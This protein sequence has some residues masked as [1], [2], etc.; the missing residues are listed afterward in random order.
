MVKAWVTTEELLQDHDSVVCHAHK[1]CPIS[2]QNSC[3]P[4]VIFPS[5]D[6]RKLPTKFQTNSNNLILKFGPWNF[7]AQRSGSH[8][9]GCSPS[10]SDGTHW[11]SL[12]FL[13]SQANSS[14]DHIVDWARDTH[15]PPL[16][17]GWAWA[18]VE[19]VRA[20]LEQQGAIAVISPFHPFP[21]TSHVSYTWN[22]EPG[23][24]LLLTS[25]QHL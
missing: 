22:L 7:S 23:G 6:V 11:C 19:A 2:F 4:K 12:I 17:L 13:S 21:Y 14:P 25:W 20:L 15:L 24:S 16:Y 9:A 18:H 3:A 10:E 5:Q 1:N 8:M